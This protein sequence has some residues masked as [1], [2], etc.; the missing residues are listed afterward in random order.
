[1]GVRPPRTKRAR[2]RGARS[3]RAPRA[4]STRG[5]S[6]SSRRTRQRQPLGRAAGRIMVGGLRST[7]G[8][9]LG[10]LFVMFVPS[11]SQDIKRRRRGSY[12]GLIIAVNLTSPDPAR[13]ARKAHRGLVDKTRSIRNPGRVRACVDDREAF[14]VERARR[15][16][17]VSAGV[18]L[19]GDD[20]GGVRRARRRQRRRH[21]H[22]EC[23]GRQ[24]TGV[25]DWSLKLVDLLRCPARRPRRRDAE[26]RRG[27]LRTST[28]RRAASTAA[29]WSP[30]SATTATAPKAVEEAPPAG[31]AG[32]G[33]RAFRTLG[34]PSTTATWDYADQRRSRKCSSR[35]A[36][37]SGAPTTNTRG[38]S[39]GD[40][41]RSGARCYAQ[42]LK[43]EKPKAKVAVLFQNDDLARTCGRVQEGDQ[44][45]TRSRSSRRRATR[46]PTRAWTRG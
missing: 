41:R 2:S 1:M 28:R 37:P 10:G 7:S 45:Q 44:G 8:P 3:S 46:S 22:R 38:R 29:R 31:G 23:E 16:T 18:L 36:P 17:A 42:Y 5:R 30:S 14:A 39:A 40:E 34:T 20:R 12:S 32:A 26:G 6:A 35:P 21:R 19:G 25:T 33:V 27:V 11:W 43:Q 9:L 15:G 24:T 13:R 4:A